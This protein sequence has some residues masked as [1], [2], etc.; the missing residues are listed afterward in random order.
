MSLVQLLHL[1]SQYPALKVLTDHQLELLL[2]VTVL[3]AL[4]DVFAHILET[5]SVMRSLFLA[6]QV[7]LAQQEPP[8]STSTSA[9]QASTLTSK[10]DSLM[11]QTQVVICAL[12]AQQVLL[13]Q[14]A[15][16]H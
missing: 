12:I 6:F 5:H 10:L 2:L 4:K 3:T 14:L 8:L 11:L 9:Q 13:A 16:T 15:P 1:C 7:T